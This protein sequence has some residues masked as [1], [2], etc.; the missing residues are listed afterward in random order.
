MGISRST[1]CDAPRRAADDAALVEARH[2]NKAAF[3][4]CGWRRMPAALGQPGRVVHHKNLKRPMREP[5]LPARRQRRHIAATDSGHDQPIVPNRAGDMVVDGPDRL[6]RE[7]LS[8]APS[9]SMP[10]TARMSQ[11]SANGPRDIGGCLAC[12]G[13]RRDQRFRCTRPDAGGRRAPLRHLP[14]ALRHRDPVRQRPALHRQGDPGLRPPARPG[15]A[16]PRCKARRA[17]ASRR[18]S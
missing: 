13:Q 2:A 7:P 8:G 5:G 17:M 14:P 4:A 18:P 6:W 1:G 9:S 12:R 11:R 16:S 10:T 15:P 3:E